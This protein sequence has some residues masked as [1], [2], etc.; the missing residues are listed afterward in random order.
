M[1]DTG[2]E[3]GQA[4]EAGGIVEVARQGRDAPA[5]QER[6]APGRGAQ[7]HQAHTGGLEAAVQAGHAQADIAATDDEHAFTP[8]A[9]RQRAEGGLV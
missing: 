7:G 9:R 5:S 8:E 2:G 3:A 6:G 1:D 4:L